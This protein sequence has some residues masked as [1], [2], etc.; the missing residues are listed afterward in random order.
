MSDITVYPVPVIRLPA[1]FPVH[2]LTS[3]EC[4]A[5]AD[6]YRARRNRWIEGCREWR[7]CDREI[8]GW[9]RLARERA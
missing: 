2:V 6:E 3:D 8:K 7:Y 9:E 4:R 5:K 1:N